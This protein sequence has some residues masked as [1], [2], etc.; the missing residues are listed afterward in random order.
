MLISKY[1]TKIFEKI[2]YLLLFENTINFE[3]INYQLHISNSNKMIIWILEVKK[4]IS[5]NKLSFTFWEYK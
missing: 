5:R 2:N 3:E 4:I 1:T